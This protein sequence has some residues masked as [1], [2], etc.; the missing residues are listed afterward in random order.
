VVSRPFCTS[1]RHRRSHDAESLE[2]GN[3]T[4]R[5]ATTKIFLDR[6]DREPEVSEAFVSL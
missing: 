5:I 1:Q 6:F 4:S 3:T 2:A